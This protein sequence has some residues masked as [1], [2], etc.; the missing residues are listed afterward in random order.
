MAAAIKAIN[1]KIR[2][3]KVLDYFCST[4]T[5]FDPAIAEAGRFNLEHDFDSQKCFAIVADHFAGVLQISG[6]L[7]QTLAFR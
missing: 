1:A 3:N 4:R 5:L 2:S 6:D 7:P